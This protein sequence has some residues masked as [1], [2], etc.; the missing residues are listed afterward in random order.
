MKIERLNLKNFGKFSEKEIVLQKGINVVYGEN[1][2]GKSTIHA[3]LRAMLFGMERGRG[4]ASL[5]DLFTRYQPLENPNYYAGIMEFESGGRHFLLERHF[6]KYSKKT[7]LACKD[8]GEQ[9]SEEQ[10]DLEILLEGMRAGEY[11]NTVSINQKHPEVSADLSRQ[12]KD[13]AAEYLASGN[14]EIQLSKALEALDKKKKEVDKQLNQNMQIK[15]QKREQL[16]N[17][18]SYIWRDI[19]RLSVEIEETQDKLQK[20]LAENFTNIKDEEYYRE[21]LREERAARKKWRVHPMAIVGM[22]AVLM[23]CF[24]LLQ[25]P[26]S[27]LWAIVIGL[28]C[29]L[30]VW[31][32]LK[33]ENKK[34]V[35]DP[36]DTADLLAERKEDIGEKLKWKVEHLLGLRKEKEIQ[37]SN[38]Q[39]QLGELESVEEEEKL[40]NKK[41]IA[42]ELAVK[43]ITNLAEEMRKQLTEK[44]NDRVS[45]IM[46]EITAGAYQKVVLDDALGIRL[47]RDEHLL[48]P[49]Q[50]SQGTLEQVFFAL[51]MAAAELL[52]EEEFPLIFDET[53]VY[54]DDNRLG[55]TLEWL[56]RNCGQVILFTCQKREMQIMKERGIDFTRI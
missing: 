20:S 51:R 48:I 15:K 53:F 46:N 3:F 29:G 55:E 33:V 13:A 56:A 5:T 37:Y 34:V 11:E 24:I 18:A 42:L 32:R 38:I 8:D 10:G 6:D 52:Y 7:I 45:E 31:N 35:Q 9:L 28:A 43:K 41:R 50:I 26:W 39:E 25:K 2:M 1:E 14:G 44:F 17:E 30:F 22:F 21:K 40:L 16:E 4:R 12:L 27:Y 47:W 23:L 54:Y 49:E 36:M 19:H